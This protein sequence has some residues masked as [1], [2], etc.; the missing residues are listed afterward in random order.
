MSFLMPK[1]TNGEVNS[2]EISNSF[3]SYD[4]NNIQEKNYEDYL[5]ELEKAG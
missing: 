1:M 5:M 3:V 2:M 4:I